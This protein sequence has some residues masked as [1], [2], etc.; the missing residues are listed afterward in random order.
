MQL[1]YM[2]ESGVE[3]LT[4]GTS[5][6]VLLGLMVPATEWKAATDQLERVKDTYGLQNVEIHTAWMHRK[7]IEQENVEGFA[8]LAKQDRIKAAQ[9]EIAR[10]AGILGVS[11]EKK[12]V[13]SYRREVAAITPY[14]HLTHADRQ[15]C[16]KD[17][18]R[19]LAAMSFVR[20]FADAISKK[21]FSAPMSPY[22]MAFE[23]ITTRSQACLFDIKDLGLLISDNNSKAAP[24]LTALSR[25]FHSSGTLYTK[26]PNIVETPLF[27]DSSLTSMI[28]MADLCAF[29]LRRFIENNETVL[30]DI[31]ENRVDELNGRKV[32]IRHYTGK[33]SCRCRICNAHGRN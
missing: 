13:T 22:E 7:Y 16:L 32:G 24:R 2:D 5:H 21:D 12:K 30:W 9:K 23:Q 3:E 31:I 27:V 29:S 25:K 17:L 19:T 10:R 28:Q 14:L 33:R 20:I 4:A 26:I 15:T 6:F 1:V 8:K 11:G 18:A